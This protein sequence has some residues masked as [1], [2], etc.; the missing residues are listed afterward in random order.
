MIKHK[1][2][3][4]NYLKADKIALKK[5]KKKP[6]FL[7]DETWKYQRLLRRIEYLQNNKNIIAS[8]LLLWTRFRKRS[9]GIKLGFEIS[10][11][12]FGPGL[13]IMHRGPIIIL[14][15]VRI[16]SGCRIH[17]CV[18]IG[19]TKGTGKGAQIGNDCY[20]GPG[21]QIVGPVTI[22][23]N[24]TIGAGAVVTKSFNEPNVII[25]GNPAKIIKTKK[26]RA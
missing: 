7:G 20:I 19:S 17:A 22:A 1:D 18:N 25:A 8:I 21:V 13:A 26:T 14:D 15:S 24:V 9:L 3:Y 12:T 23:D 16:G 4:E 11:Y 2:D 10:P 5:R 6:G